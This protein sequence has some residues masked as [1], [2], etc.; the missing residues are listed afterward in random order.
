[1]EKYFMIHKADEPKSKGYLSP[2]RGQGNREFLWDSIRHAYL[3][4]ENSLTNEN[5]ISFLNGVS[6]QVVNIEN[7][8]A[9]ILYK[10]HERY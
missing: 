2:W 8:A 4:D 10:Y 1:M 6:Y 7:D 5:V 3:F 9:N